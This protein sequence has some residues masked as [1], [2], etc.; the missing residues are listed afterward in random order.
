MSPLITGSSLER[1]ERCPNSYAYPQVNSTSAASEKGTE[2]HAE[3]ERAIRSEEQGSLSNELWAFITSFTNRRTEVGIALNVH[4][5]SVRFI[6]ARNAGGYDGVHPGEIALTVDFIGER[7]GK[8]WCI[9][10]KSRA[11]VTAAADNRQLLAGVV[12]TGATV[13]AIYYLDNHYC[14]KHEFSQMELDAFWPLADEILGG[15][16]DAISVKATTKGAWEP[17]LHE[18]PWC[19][20]CPAKFSCHAKTSYIK[21]AL[22]IAPSEILS[23]ERAGEIWGEI[24]KAKKIV[25][26]MEEAI[27]LMSK[28]VDIPLKGGKVLRQ[29]PVTTTKVDAKA[30][31]AE[32][33]SAG[34]EVPKYSFT[35]YTTKEVKP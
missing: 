2:N 35:Y 29:I 10:W 24:K 27:K 1:A 8:V 4:T 16:A 14:D 18:G 11:R 17:S 15:V 23:A 9:D 25:E 12:G 7:D 26:T 3:I 30:M 20:Y 31:E 33:V 32:C 5:K 19:D 28:D 22:A 34:K 6:G 13:G 21:H